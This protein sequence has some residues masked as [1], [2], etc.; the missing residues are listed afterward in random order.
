M[1]TTPLASNATKL[2]IFTGPGKIPAD[3]SSYRQIAVQLQNASGYVAKPQSTDITVYM[4]SNDSSV[5]RIDQIRIPADQ[6]YALA[7]LNTTYKPGLANITAVANDFPLTNQSISTFGF[8]P[9]KLMVYCIPTSLPSDGQTY[10]T[11][12]VQLQDSQGRPAKST[13]TGVNVMLFS[14]Q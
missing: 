14:S 11:I 9:S 8:I 4:T 10:Q 7:K 3:Q 13:E 1:T 2:R 6:T 5:C 12:Q